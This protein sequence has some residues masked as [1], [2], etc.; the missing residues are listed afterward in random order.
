M[1]ASSGDYSKR[2]ERQLA[3][4]ELARQ[5]EEGGFGVFPFDLI[6]VKFGLQRSSRFTELQSIVDEWVTSASIYK[7]RMTGPPPLSVTVHL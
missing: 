4:K 6:K 1:D 2:D 7:L 5:P 3:M